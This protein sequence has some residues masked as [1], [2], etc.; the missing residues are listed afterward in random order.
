MC[1]PTPDLCGA[2]GQT[3]G[4]IYARHHSSQRLSPKSQT[5]DNLLREAVQILD[6]FFNTYAHIMN[7]L[8]DRSHNSSRK[9]LSVLRVLR[10]KSS[11]IVSVA[12]IKHSDRK[13]LREKSIS[14]GF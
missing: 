14:F 4:F 1:T 9:R 12:V 7:Y 5:L 10:Q 2:E 11:S 13:Q 8:G 3:Q 6:F